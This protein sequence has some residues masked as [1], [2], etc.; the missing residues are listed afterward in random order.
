MHRFTPAARVPPMPNDALAAP[1]H[2]TNA[3]PQMPAGTLADYMVASETSRRTIVRDCKYS[4]LG[5]L[6]QH[7]EARA[8]ISRFLLTEPPDLAMLQTAAAT[9]RAREVPSDFMCALWAYNAGYIERFASVWPALAWP[10]A[11]RSPGGALP[12]FRLNG[13]QIT[14]ELAVRLDRAGRLDRTGPLD[15][16]RRANRLQSGGAMLRYAKDRPLSAEIGAWQ[17]ALLLGVLRG[18]TVDGA[19]IDPRLCLTVDAWA[20]TTYPAPSDA[21]RRC[22]RLA[23]ACAS[24]AEWWDAVP[25]PR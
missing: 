7:A 5:R 15:R 13:V 9:L 19:T 17:S 3:V 8:T 10:H 25:P 21:V 16:T 11:A 22:G 18:Q 1:T 12:G 4:P 20:G 6:I 14:L 23:A 2:G 24:I